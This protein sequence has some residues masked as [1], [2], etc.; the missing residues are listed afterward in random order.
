M[1]S[2]CPKCH[3]V[4]EQ[5]EVCCA[6]V[7]YTWRCLKCHKLTTGFVM[8]YGKCYLCGGELE[9]MGDREIGDP[10]GHEALR[11]AMQ[12]ELN[13]YYFYRLAW[14]R[15]QNPQHRVIFEYMYQNEL[16]HLRE[17]EEK[18]HAHLGEGVLEMQPELE[19]LLADEIFKGIDYSEHRSAEQLY[20]QAIQMEQRTRDFFVEAAR[21]AD[22]FEKEL[23]QELSA[24]EEEHIAMLETEMKQ[25]LPGVQP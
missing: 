8:P 21:T 25:F 11:T 15:T 14:K 23:Y 12:F 10:L 6:Q 2:F 4:L 7:R 9:G 24:E 5:D 1:P 18:Y 19:E 22:G 13:A 20:R 16:D 3:R 17:L